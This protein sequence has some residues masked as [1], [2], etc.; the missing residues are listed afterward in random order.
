MLSIPTETQTD[1]YVEYEFVISLHRVI[2]GTS[3]YL[4]LP[5]EPDTIISVPVCQVVNFNSW[6]LTS[7]FPSLEFY[8]V[9]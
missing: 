7:H 6:T 8:I 9:I 5:A 3:E 4:K 1:S 2:L